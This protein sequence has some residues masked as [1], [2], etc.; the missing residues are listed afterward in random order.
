MARAGWAK[1][2]VYG[3]VP[4]QRARAYRASSRR[5][6]RERRGV[7]GRCGGNFHRPA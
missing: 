1:V 7:F 2:Y 5:A 3:G 4:F 6:R